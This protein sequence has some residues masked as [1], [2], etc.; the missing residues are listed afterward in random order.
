MLIGEFNR[1]FARHGKW[2]FGAILIVLGVSMLLFYGP[3]TD[4][5]L[6][7]RGDTNVIGYVG[8]GKDSTTITTNDFRLHVARYAIFSRQGADWSSPSQ[9][10]TVAPQIFSD[11]QLI[12]HAKE[13]GM[14]DVTNEEV[15]DRIRKD[16]T[17]QNDDG[18]FDR[19]KYDEIME[20]LGQRGLDSADFASI[21]RTQIIIGRVR[22]RMQSSLT[23]PAN[24]GEWMAA[25]RGVKS[26]VQVRKYSYLSYTDQV[27]VTD[28]QVRERY[29][30]E[31]A[32]TYLVP[33]KRSLMVVEIPAG[34][35]ALS[36]EPDE[37][38]LEAYYEANL[39]HYTQTRAHAGEIF[40][41]V[42]A[43][44]TQEQKDA[45]KAELEAIAERARGGEDFAT[46]AREHTEWPL[47]KEKG[48]DLGWFTR[49]QKPGAAVVF[50]ME[51]GEVSAVQTRSDGYR[52]YKKYDSTTATRPLA[53]V[54]NQVT[55]A[56]IMAR[57]SQYTEDKA[58]EL[59]EER[60]AQ[61]AD[62]LVARHILIAYAGSQ[63]RAETSRTK[64]EA[65]ALA[66]QV[67]DEARA[68]GADF[69]ALAM[70]YSMGPSAR[71]G[72][73]LPP[74]GEGEMVEPFYN[75]AK[76]MSPGQISEPV[77]T[78]FGYH[79]IK[80]ESI[81]ARFEDVKAQLLSEVNQQR[82]TEG[83]REANLLAGEI[84]QAMSKA[85]NDDSSDVTSTEET[86]SKLAAEKGLKAI[87]TEPFTRDAYLVTY[88][89]ENGVSQPLRGFRPDS[90]AYVFS[91]LSDLRRLGDSQA[92]SSSVFVI[93]LDE[94]ID[95]QVPEFSD[96]LAATIREDI[97]KDQA[98]AMA[99]EKAREAEATLRADL[100]AGKSLLDATG[101]TML[102]TPLPPFT[103]AQGPTDADGSVIKTAA[104]KTQ[105]GELAG[106]FDTATGAVIVY[107]QS[108]SLPPASEI[109]GQG[110][111]ME[112]MIARYYLQSDI[113]SGTEERLRDRFPILLTD[114]W[115]YLSGDTPQ[116]VTG[117]DPESL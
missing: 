23:I 111:E 56:V 17:F 55:Q 27:E 50:Q 97:V 2:I 10:D 90:I 77:E 67:R 98:I 82:T 74:F 7:S 86:L 34:P 57:Q 48:G 80:L 52:I 31:K 73:M 33:E 105:A 3:N 68:D 59:F 4:Q 62:R 96:E 54:R 89:D 101:S 29:E 69:A 66:E 49:E 26:T 14:A 21:I 115:A 95:S 13:L 43:D 94:I 51:N 103:L 116:D 6:T 24:Y 28:A 87:K 41:A 1:Y 65:L 45:R 9:W 81:G 79:I 60:K 100:E 107:V 88:L 108:H 12:E 75:A 5:A 106:A 70:K 30:A 76:A 58:R 16:P 20:N 11:L 39:S 110:L 114:T 44:A 112:N 40:L 72:G 46:L 64:E 15:A 71:N 42:D 35:K 61:Y 83:K 117:Q 53:E 109:A 38:D 93:V 99:R 63:A 85:L 19:S 102:F 25:Y 8:E 104:E 84:V 113:A 92:G 78:Q 37:A 32:T 18:K 91:K 47:L 36:I 22:S